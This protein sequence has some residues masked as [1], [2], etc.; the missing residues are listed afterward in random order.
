MVVLYLLRRR[1]GERPQL[2]QPSGRKQSQGAA[3]H[4]GNYGEDGFFF[5]KETH[6]FENERRIL[7][8]L[9][10]TSDPMSGCTPEFH[11]VVEL[12][13]ARYIKMRSLLEGFDEASMCQMDVKMGVRCFSESESVMLSRMVAASA[14]AP[15]AAVRPSGGLRPVMEARFFSKRKML[16]KPCHTPCSCSLGLG[17]GEPSA[18]CWERP[19]V[20]DGG[21]WLGESGRWPS[22][23]ASAGLGA[24]SSSPRS[25]E[26]DA[27]AS[28]AKTPLPAPGEW[29]LLLVRFRCSRAACSFSAALVATLRSTSQ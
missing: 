7:E 3:G 28:S 23:D 19:D 29:L 20:G 17:G 5:K 26:F 16:R 14:P 9:R 22:A 8:R 24:S 11:G 2:S 25:G 12:D 15:S 1:R 6:R 21:R 13:G 27:V 10:D 4:A 18:E